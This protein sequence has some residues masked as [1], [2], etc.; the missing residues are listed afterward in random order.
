[1]GT[2]G[3]KAFKF[4]SDGNLVWKTE[5][6][7]EMKEG[8]GPRE[9]DGARVGEGFQKASQVNSIPAFGV[10]EKSLYALV[11]CTVNKVDTTT[12]KLLWSMK[13]E[14]ATGGFLASPAIDKEDNLYVGTKSN[15]ESTLFAIGSSG[16]LLWKNQIGADLYTSPLLGADNMIYTGSETTDRGKYYKID[17][18]SGEI[19]WVIGK[20][21][22]DFT[23]DSGALYKGYVYI[24]VHQAPE[25][26]NPQPKK[27]LFKIKVDTDN[28]QTGSPWP[29]FHG[30]NANTGRK[31]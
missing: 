30:G 11:G 17:M 10:G 26:G 14:G 31:E 27:T 4:T 22:S 13:P 18:K 3:I 16:K 7:N 25:E 19:K 28:Y 23:L 29:R 24:G 21:V 5:L 20:A 6:G 9:K 15:L 8:E 12:G 1:M 2:E